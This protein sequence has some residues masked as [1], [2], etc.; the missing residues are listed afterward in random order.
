MTIVL[1][2]LLLKNTIC[3]PAGRV[4]L[5]LCLFPESWQRI[6]SSYISDFTYRT[7]HKIECWTALSVSMSTIH[8]EH[9][10]FIITQLIIE[11]MAKS[12]TSDRLLYFKLHVNK[13][14]RNCIIFIEISYRKSCLSLFVNI[15][16]VST[17]V[18]SW[19]KI[20]SRPMDRETADCQARLRAYK[21]T[22]CIYKHAP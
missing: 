2:C 12:Y 9:Y 17:I 6:A 4:S 14:N 18:T 5:K 15:L 8:T 7:L 1:H 13:I 16:R 11:N 20:D 10:N 22:V 3:L 19:N 21:D